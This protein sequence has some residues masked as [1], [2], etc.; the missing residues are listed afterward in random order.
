MQILFVHPSFPGQFGP[1][2]EHLAGSGDT[3][4]VFVSRAESIHARPIPGVRRI[5]YATRG[6]ATRTTHYTSR[7]FENAV[8]SA[9]GVFEACK[10]ADGLHPDLI[11]GHS[12]FGTTAFLQELYGCP[13]VSHFEYYYRSRGTDLDFRPDQPPSELDRLRTY[14]RNA[15][16][17][18]DLEACAAGTTPTHWQWGLLP[19]TLRDKV[20]VIHDGIDTGFWHRRPRP[21]VLAGEPLAPETKVVTYVARG[22]EAMRGFDVFVQ[23]ANRIAAER[24]DVL[25]VVV[26]ADDAAY[27]GD[28][29]HIE[30]RTFKEHVLKRE[31]PDLSRFRFL[32]QVPPDTLADVFSA[33]DVHVYLTVPFVL[34][35]SLL[36]A[37][38]CECPVVASDTAPVREV[39]DHGQTGLLADF[40]D[41]D[42]LARHA[43]AVLQDP[44]GHRALGQA[45]RGLVESRYALE[46]TLPRLEALYSRARGHAAG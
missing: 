29:R 37:L 25:F 28:T 21:S 18:L 23:V 8:W 36:D 2:V 13:V 42:G 24:S 20:E 5:S 35:W 40:F 19:E 34:S 15:M 33:S 22:L 16:I 17:L 38:A 31:Q 1:V 10:A 30:E 43:L 27:G 12:G 41:A 3:E 45:G 32:G 39:I 14:T 4:C 9:H 26:G 44:E 7:T 11:V 46:V 6:G